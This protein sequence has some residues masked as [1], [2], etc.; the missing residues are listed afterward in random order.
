MVLLSERNLAMNTRFALCCFLAGL[1]WCN[2]LFSRDGTATSAVELI[3]TGS[4]G[5]DSLDLSG[6]TGT[7]E[8]DT[9]ADQLGGF[10]ALDY[11][12]VANRY[13]VL[14]DRGPGDGAATFA[15]R[16]H[17]LDLDIDLDQKRITPTLRKSVLLRNAGGEQFVG[18]LKAVNVRKPEKGLAL[19]SEGLRMIDSK[20]IAITDEYGPSLRLFGIDGIQQRYWPLPSEFALNPLPNAPG[21]RG[22]FPNRGLE[23]LAKSSDGKQLIAAMQG[24]LIQDGVV[25]GEKCLGV[26]TRWLCVDMTTGKSKQW[27]YPLSNESTGVSEVLAVDATRYMV[28]ERDSRLGVDANIKHIYLVDSKKA[29]DVSGENGF[30]RTELPKNVVELEKR[31]LIDLR[32]DSFGL[33]GAATAEKPEGLCWGPQLKE[34]RRLL[35]VCV[36][37]DFKVDRQSEFYAFALRL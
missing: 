1:G 5:G 30:A 16:F 7:L 29:T 17:E 4:L 19:D 33:G 36:D 28:L 9:R 22:T 34:G 32:D 18:S 23:G 37:N 27:V 25:E 15:C 10:S 21:A 6:V 3:A 11:T 13:W 2:V 35:V 12:G 26:N 8:T 14:S 31:L 24:P 20:S